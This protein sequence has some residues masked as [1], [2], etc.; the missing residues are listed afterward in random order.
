MCLSSPNRFSGRQ[1]RQLGWVGWGNQKGV[2]KF[3]SVLIQNGRPVT[4]DDTCSPN[5]CQA[6]NMAYINVSRI[7]PTASPILF[8]PS[9]FIVC[10]A[11]ACHNPHHLRDNALDF[12]VSPAWTVLGGGHRS[13]PVGTPLTS[14]KFPSPRNST[15]RPCANPSPIG[16]FKVVGPWTPGQT[17]RVGWVGKPKRCLQVWLSLDPKWQTRNN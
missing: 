10:A 5:A 9:S 11:R 17:T 14:S 3:G 8:P 1:A 15:V 16:T 4:I 7:V 13:T 2:C 12:H 6:L